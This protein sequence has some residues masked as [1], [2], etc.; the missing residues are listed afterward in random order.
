MN[1]TPLP[2]K[3]KRNPS[4]D[5]LKILSFFLVVCVHFCT[6]SGF[7]TEPHMGFTMYVMNVAYAFSNTCVALFIMMTGFLMTN[8]RL[9][10]SYYKG[11]IRV[12]IMYILCCD[13]CLIYKVVKYD[14][15]LSFY[16]WTK[17]ILDFS[18][19]DYGWYFEMYL[20]LFILIPFLNL[21]YHGLDTRKKKLVLLATMIALTALPGVLNIF[22]F[23][24]GGWWAQPSLSREYMKLIPNFWAGF[25]PVTFYFIGCYL[26]E[27]PPKLK[28]RY[29]AAIWLIS[30]ILWAS[31]N[32]YRFYGGTFFWGSFAVNASLFNVITATA[33]FALISA[34]DLR[35]AP[36]PVKK[37]MAYTAKCTF[38]AYLLSAIVDMSVN[39]RFKALI[40]DL[41][42]Q[43]RCA[44]VVVLITFTISLILSAV[45]NGV[46]DLV[47]HLGK[48]AFA[49]LQK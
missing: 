8:K 13:V 27:Y 48:K 37:V 46:Y 9:S 12:V 19:S 5:L 11:I 28:K 14:Y 18:A 42:E 41:S 34:M 32:F 16:E 22:N 36:G 24:L 21:A 43:Y 38:S 4:I 49:R 47:A 2:P 10:K 45:L 23:E 33:F 35:A 7:M 44:P 3:S 6:H 31:F 29:I 17:R 15:A 39:S 25:Y 1:S 20:G 30:G 40:P 26:R